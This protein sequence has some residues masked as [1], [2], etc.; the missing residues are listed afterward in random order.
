MPKLVLGRGGGVNEVFR[1]RRTLDRKFEEGFRSSHNIHMDGQV[2]QNDKLLADVGSDDGHYDVNCDGRKI[3]CEVSTEARRQWIFNSTT[4]LV[5]KAFRS[6]TMTSKKTMGV[7]SSNE[8]R[9]F[10]PSNDANV[11]VKA[12]EDVGTLINGS[13]RQQSMRSRLLKLGLG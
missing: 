5:R 6:R 9:A 13:G 3:P 2:R 1:S 4:D 7:Q 8:K 10:P 11:R 12:N